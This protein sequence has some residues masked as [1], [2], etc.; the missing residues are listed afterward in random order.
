M[1]QVT[2]NQLVRIISTKLNIA[3]TSSGWV[4]IAGAINLSS[5]RVRGMARRTNADMG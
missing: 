2:Y 4:S 3:T 1:A 5:M